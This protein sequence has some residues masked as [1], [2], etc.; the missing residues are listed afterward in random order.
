MRKVD[1]GDGATNLARASCSDP[2]LSDDENRV[3]SNAARLRRERDAH[4]AGTR[5]GFG[6]G[7]SH[8]IKQRKKSAAT[9]NEHDPVNCGLARRYAMERQKRHGDGVAD[10]KIILPKV[11]VKNLILARSA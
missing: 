3:T 11:M 1:A 8:P 2:N 4:M 7:W 10:G 5:R 9:S 6:F